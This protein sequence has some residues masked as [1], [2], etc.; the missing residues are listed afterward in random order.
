MCNLIKLIFFKD[1]MFIFTLELI[2]SLIGSEGVHFKLT[3]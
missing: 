3:V 1:D 2:N